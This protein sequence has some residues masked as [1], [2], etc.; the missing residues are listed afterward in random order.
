MNLETW[1]ERN[2]HYLTTAI[3]WLRLR[4]E[5]MARQNG[6]VPSA[7]PGQ[8][9]ECPVPA[10]GQHTNPSARSMRRLRWLGRASGPPV[11][12][13]VEPPPDMPLLLSTPGIEDQLKE[14]EAARAEAERMEPPPALSMLS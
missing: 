12:A 13:V 4:L 5:R 9:V 11:S 2:S 1:Q 6:A 10:A 7:P 14:A 3:K 8:P